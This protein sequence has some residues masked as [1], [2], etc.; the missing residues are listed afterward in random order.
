MKLKSAYIHA[1]VS[2]LQ[3]SGCSFVD[4]SDVPLRD[5]IQGVGNTRNYWICV[6]ESIDV[7][8]NRA[9]WIEECLQERTSH[10]LNFR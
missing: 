9:K 2:C 1:L 8:A 7:K 6:S 3:G 10:A 5:S 4:R